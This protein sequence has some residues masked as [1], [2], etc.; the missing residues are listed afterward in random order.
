MRLQSMVFV[1]IVHI[2][3]MGLVVYLAEF[4][5]ETAYIRSQI[6]RSEKLNLISE[7]AASV[8]HEVRNPLT[9]VR[10]FVQLLREDS[11]PKNKE[12]IHLMLTELDRAEFIISD[13]LNLAKPQAGVTDKFD[14]S[15]T[16]HEVIEIMSSFALM[17][18]V[19]IQLLT[20]RE[21]FVRGEKVKIKQALMNLLKNGIEAM[22]D[23]EGV[24][25]VSVVKSGPNIVVC[26]RDQGEGMTNE[27]IEN[28]GLPFYSTKEKG[29]GLGLMVTFRII[30]SMGGSLEF[31][32][33]RGKGTT[34]TIR[35]PALAE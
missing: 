8:A 30:E 28:L 7:L 15:E 22:N 6:H 10:G 23:N 32:S 35:I 19:H 18:G 26:I 24:I 11:N 33:D 13:Y 21:L 34:A 12:Y 1:A 2:L 25:K 14:V 5:R 4:V 9:V 31:E 16:A 20:D 29:T 27:Q 3:A 17:N